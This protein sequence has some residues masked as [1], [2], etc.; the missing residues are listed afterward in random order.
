MKT[1]LDIQSELHRRGYYKGK[2]DGIAGPQTRYAIEQFQSANDLVRDGKVG[3]KTLAKLFPAVAVP[4]DEGLTTSAAGRAAITLREDNR[5]TAYRD[6]VG[7]LTIGVGHTSEAGPPTVTPGMVIT[8]AESDAILSRDL[9]TFEKAVLDAVKVPLS[10][11]E[12]DALVS[13]AFNIGGGAFSKSTLVK[14]LNAGDRVGAADAFM[15]WV[16]AG[17][18]TVKGLGNRRKSERLQFLG[19]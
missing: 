3:P 18:K 1:T 15:S 10:Q 16:K 6:S 9:K 7:V 17:G 5:L 13:L 2:L 4:S 11:H 8:A 19:D 12:F 14:K